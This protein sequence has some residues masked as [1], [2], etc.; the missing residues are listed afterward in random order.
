MGQPSPLL[1]VVTP[2]Q[3]RE[4]TPSRLPPEYNRALKVPSS[5]RETMHSRRQS[6]RLRAQSGANPGTNVNAGKTWR[7][8]K[9]AAEVPANW[10]SDLKASAAHDAA[11][12]GAPPGGFF[13]RPESSPGSRSCGK[14]SR[15]AVATLDSHVT[16]D[17]ISRQMSAFF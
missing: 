15:A 10:V 14:D 8:R 2:R 12:K 13:A 9:R 3:T 4:R 11:V 5:E 16:G 7:P 17:G 6:A 1:A